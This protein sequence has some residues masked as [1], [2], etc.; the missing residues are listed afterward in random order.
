[1]KIEI[2]DNFDSSTFSYGQPNMNP[3]VLINLNKSGSV[4][5]VEQKENL[6]AYLKFGISFPESLEEFSDS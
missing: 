2:L 6:E 5:L 1:M 3:D 4:Y